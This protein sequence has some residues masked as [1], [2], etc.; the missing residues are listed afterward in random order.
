MRTSLQTRVMTPDFTP[1]TP[2]IQEA[3]KCMNF[4]SSSL[5]EDTSASVSSNSNSSLES[6]IRSPRKLFLNRFSLKV[7]SVSKLDERRDEKSPLGEAGD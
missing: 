5:V 2:T 3:K 1:L 7:T 4:Q 6:P